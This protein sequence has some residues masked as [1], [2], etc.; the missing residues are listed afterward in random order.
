[1]DDDFPKVRALFDYQGR[2]QTE[3][4][5]NAGDTITILDMIDE[6]W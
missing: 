5:F 4:S 3:L 6:S 2:S 1:M